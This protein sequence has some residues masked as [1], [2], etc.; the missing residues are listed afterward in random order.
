MT[1]RSRA[2]DKL[3]GAMAPGEGRSERT[4]LPESLRSA[5]ERTIQATSGTAAETA[6]RA[7]ELL[8]EVAR[9]GER[10][11]QDISGM[12]FASARDVRDLSDRLERIDARLA[13]L[14]SESKSQPESQG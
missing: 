10:T 13:A 6:E 9:R 12:R 4:G 7:Q 8:D 14:E 11:R 5:V 3:S 2:E 1:P